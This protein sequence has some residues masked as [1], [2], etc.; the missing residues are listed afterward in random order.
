VIIVTS[1]VV[2]GS[3]AVVARCTASAW[4]ALRARLGFTP[5]Q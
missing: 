4:Q 3:V 5:D 2:G 1:G